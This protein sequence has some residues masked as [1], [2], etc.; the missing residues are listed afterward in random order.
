MNIYRSSTRARAER[1]SWKN[2]VFYPPPQNFG[3]HVTVL[4]PAGAPFPPPSVRPSAPQGTD[5]KCYTGRFLFTKNFEK[6]TWKGPSNEERVP[7]DTSSIRLCSRRQN[8][9]RWQRY[10]CEEPETAL[11][12]LLN[13]TCIP[14]DGF[15]SDNRTTFSIFQLYRGL[16]CRPIEVTCFL[17]NVY[18]WQVFS[19]QLIAGST[20]FGFLQCNG[21]SLTGASPLALA[22]STY[23]F[24]SS[25]TLYK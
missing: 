12:K 16:R 24:S 22:K 11:R 10:R 9:R 8:S 25:K 2:L 20:V 1:H 3:S 14:L 5:V 23:Y 21:F 15:Q 18:R 4:A 7:F 19:F 13:G 6:L 17:F